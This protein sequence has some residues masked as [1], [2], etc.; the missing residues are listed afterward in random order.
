MSQCLLDS[1]IN[2]SVKIF[3]PLQD[4]S[5]WKHMVSMQQVGT[6]LSS[7]PQGWCN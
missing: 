6:H 4:L 7:L 3:P 5:L 2:I 1:Y